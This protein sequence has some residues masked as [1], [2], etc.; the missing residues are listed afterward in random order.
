MEIKLIP[1]IAGQEISPYNAIVA[2]GIQANKVK[3]KADFSQLPKQ[4]AKYGQKSK[5]SAN[6]TRDQIYSRR[7]KLGNIVYPER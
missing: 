5:I 7:H 6:Q 2:G 1:S 4:K 3:V